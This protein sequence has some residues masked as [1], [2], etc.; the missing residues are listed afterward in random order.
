MSAAF[1][2]AVDGA[3]EQITK[4]LDGVRYVD[5]YARSHDTAHGAVT[6]NLKD[7][8]IRTFPVSDSMVSSSFRADHHVAKILCKLYD[9]LLDFYFHALDLLEEDVRKKGSAPKKGS[10]QK[11][12]SVTWKSRMQELVDSFKLAREE[13]DSLIQQETLNSVQFLIDERLHEKGDPGLTIASQ[14]CVPLTLHVHS[15]SHNSR[16]SAAT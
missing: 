9:Y 16:C 5:S 13:L 12:A 1:A 2:E 15:S 14:K 3:K 6:K 10:L 8:R 7:I 11:S 4:V